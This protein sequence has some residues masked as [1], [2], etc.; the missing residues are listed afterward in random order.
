[1]EKYDLQKPKQDKNERKV[2]IRIDIEKSELYCRIE[3]K[4]QRI[5]EK[6][7]IYKTP[8]K[9]KGKKNF[10]HLVMFPYPSGDL[11]IG[12]WYNFVGADVYARL[13]RLQGFNVLSPIGFDAFGLPAE[14]AA[15]RHKIHPRTWTQKNIKKMR[16]QLKSIGAVYD[17][18]REIITCE[19]E[20][21]K[22][23]Q[24]MF[25]QFFK[26]GLAFKK[27]APANWCPECKSILAN[28]QAEDGKCWRCNNQV[29]Q[30]EVEQ[31]FFKITSYAEELLN[32]LEKLDW[33]EKTKIMQKNW[34][35]RS[36]GS[37]IKFQIADSKLQINVFT[38]R[39]DT[40]FG[41]TYLVLAP[42]H[43]II[44]ELKPQI[45]N[46]KFVREYIEKSKH[47]TER[48]RIS[49][50]KEKSGIELKG[51]K[52]INPAN[53]RQ[54]PIFVAD[55]VLIH[56][57]T[58]AIMAVPSHDQRDW[59][60][61]KKYNL[62]IIEV[63]KPPNK[64]PF[65]YFSKAYEEEGV[66]INSGRFDGMKSEIARKRIAEWLMKRGLAKKAIFY[67]LRDWLISRQRY[68]GA[69]IPILYCQKCG[70]VPVPE[71]DLPVLLPKIKD[72]LPTTDGKSPLAKSKKFVETVCPKCH[73]LA[74]RETDT[75][76]TFICSSWYYLRY[77]DS[78]NTKK[79]ALKQKLKK[80]LPVDMYVGGAEH[81]V[82]HL[83]YSRFFTKAL[84]KMGH[85]HFS[86]PFLSLRH[87]GIILGP[88]KQKM[89]K[90]RGNVI[91]PDK[92]V[93]KYGSDTVRMYLCFMG[94][95]EQGGPW[96]PKGIVG[97]YRFLN[98]VWDL[99]TTKPETKD[100]KSQAKNQ[101]LDKLLHKTIKKV[102]EDIENF[103]FNTAISSL[104][105]LV[106][107]L[108]INREQ[109]TKNNLKTLLLLLAPFAPHLT[110]ELWQRLI[111]S[112][113]QF[114]IQNS[115][116]NQLWPKYNPKLIKEKNFTLIIQ[117]NGKVRDKI[118]V[119]A[120]ILEEKAKELALNRE[121]VK[122]W[123]E[124]KK[125]K[126]VIFVPGKLINIVT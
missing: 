66:L 96:D 19:P 80:W 87:Q 37:E 68:W 57:G 32:D 122:K 29:E 45:I 107:E 3:K 109:L 108:S 98:R 54:I 55:Y 104:M 31:W 2:K 115:I 18:E 5:W 23:T 101:H 56:Y 120:D 75:M 125:V 53:N 126:K 111:I 102:T 90:S 114:L 121:K 81:A 47:K 71:K 110:E 38:T 58:G 40:L 95:Y 117:V 93:K 64:L 82:L 49:E 60:F 30:K 112:N 41:C 22:W 99:L 24:W 106:N 84:K 34:I 123:L 8:D 86:E 39:A 48:E 16:R 9:I 105:I 70:V 76:D 62:P 116:H 28:E 10:Y 67:K 78:K 46:Y 13:K 42:E 63:I 65:G 26:N 36:E 89:S 61:A 7:G 118:E 79:F 43:P 83:L 1:M 51:I 17:W 4:W 74:E 44:E 69:P 72:Y 91:D 100:K 50:V 33:P 11:H 15:I 85:I 88:D 77:V 113:S 119:E 27:K 124:D 14:N 12:H 92:Q 94:P 59:E 21:Y 25:L 52:G 20:Y 103:R 6:Y 35:G 97:I 73:S